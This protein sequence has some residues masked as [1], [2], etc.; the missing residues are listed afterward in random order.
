MLIIP[1]IYFCTKNL[2]M[3]C[4]VK[5]KIWIF[6]PFSVLLISIIFSKLILDLIHS[7]SCDSISIKIVDS[8]NLK[9][10]LFNKHVNLK[11]FMCTISVSDNSELAGN[12]KINDLLFQSN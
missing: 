2:F 4:S 6:A 8:R 10:T 1:I 12:F 5:R 3:F 9:V 11:S 7:F